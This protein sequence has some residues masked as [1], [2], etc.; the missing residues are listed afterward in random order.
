MSAPV[1][2]QLAILNEFD[3]PEPRMIALVR[4]EGG[5][6]E[7]TYLS[8]SKRLRGSQWLKWNPVR[9][10]KEMTPVEHFGVKPVIELEDGKHVIGVVAVAQSIAEYSDGAERDWQGHTAERTPIRTKLLPALKAWQL[11]HAEASNA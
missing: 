11:Q 5:A 6:L 8:A 1:R 9:R 4:E 7:W 10:P 2:Y 3:R